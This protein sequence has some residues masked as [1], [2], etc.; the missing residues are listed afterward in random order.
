MADINTVIAD[1]LTAQNDAY[2]VAEHDYDSASWK[3]IIHHHA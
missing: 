3:R 2:A 1:I